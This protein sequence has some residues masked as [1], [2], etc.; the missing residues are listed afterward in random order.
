MQFTISAA[1]L[2]ALVSAASAQTAGFDAITAPA[3]AEVVP[4]CS[5]YK[6]T[7]D[8]VS[9]YAGTVSIQLL[10]GATSTTLQL[11]PVIASGVDN[12]LGAYTWAVDCALGDDATYGIK[13]I[14]DND[15]SGVTFQYSNPFSISKAAASSSSSSSAAAAPTSA[16]SSAQIAED[17]GDAST[18]YSTQYM[19][20]TSCAATVTDCPARSTVVSSTSFPVVATGPSSVPVPVSSNA[21]Q[22]GATGVPSSFTT[23]S[24]VVTGA[25]APIYPAGNATTAGLGGVGGT[26]TLSTKTTTGSGSA[27]TTSA[28]ATAGAGRVAMGGVAA[29][30]GF[31]AAVFAL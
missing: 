8:Y 22:T 31:A 18:V 29:V 4:A 17:Y 2:L 25:P 16:T 19:T 12:S 5:N 28:I 23:V 24:P 3:K 20:I 6:L 30:A 1:T 10:Q 21:A 14:Y 26:V 7:W 9:T 27:A 11:G 15:A 13:I